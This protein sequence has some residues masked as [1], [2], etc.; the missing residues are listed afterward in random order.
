[1]EYFKSVADA[2]LEH[3]IC[4]ELLNAE[5]AELAE[6]GPEDFKKGGDL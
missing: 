6:C 3:M 1:V 5:A 2:V 4:L